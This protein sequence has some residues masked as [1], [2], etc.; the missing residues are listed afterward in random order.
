MLV[1]EVFIREFGGSI[2]GLRSCS[3]AIDKV[4]SLKRKRAQEWTQVLEDM[5]H[6]YDTVVAIIFKAQRDV[7][8][9]STIQSCSTVQRIVYLDH[10][11]LYHPVKVAALVSNRLLILQMLACAKCFEVGRG[12]GTLGLF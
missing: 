11:I 5:K 12:F 6:P 3:I 4:A 7:I 1:H 8:Y 10:E 2:D 9:V